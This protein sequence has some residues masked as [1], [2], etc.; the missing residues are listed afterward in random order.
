MPLGYP[1]GREYPPLYPDWET[2][3]LPRISDSLLGCVFYVYPSVPAARRGEDSGGT[4]FL[5]AARLSSGS[6]YGQIYGVT[7]KHVARDMG[8]KNVVLRLNTRDGSTE[9]VQTK[10]SDWILDR[11]DLAVTPLDLSGKRIRGTVIPD[12]QFLTEEHCHIY[13]VGPGEET[14]MVGRFVTHDGRQRNTPMVRFGNI[15]MMPTEPI[16]TREGEQIAFL[17]EC[18]SLSGFSGSPVFLWMLAGS[19][20]PNHPEPLMRPHGPWLLGVNCGHLVMPEKSRNVLT[21]KKLYVAEHSGIE[22][23]IP[24]WKLQTVLNG[25]DLKNRRLLVEREVSEGKKRGFIVRDPSL[26]SMRQASLSDV[27]T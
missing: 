14:F 12:S 10:L 25:E 5:V 15:A 24:S 22:V 19:S 20:R 16:R 18:R 7:N 21:G 23:A 3:E 17:I 27:Q 2:A 8:S 11:E 1:L 13:N 26:G 9:L 4:G 6:D